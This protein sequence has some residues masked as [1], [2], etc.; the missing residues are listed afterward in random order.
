M[1]PRLSLTV[2]ARRHIVH[3]ESIVTLHADHKDLVLSI[4]ER[5]WT[6][7]RCADGTRDI[8]GIVA[9]VEKSGR[10]VRQDH[11]IA[12]FDELETAGLIINGAMFDPGKM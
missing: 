12:F 8:D 1:R 5:E 3:G 2:S 6:V 9:A 4:G 10:A 7:L 11:L